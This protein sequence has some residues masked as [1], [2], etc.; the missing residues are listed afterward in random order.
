MDDAVVDKKVSSQ[1]APPALLT[2]PEDQPSNAEPADPDIR[3][4]V[5]IDLTTE[6]R[7]FFDGP[8]PTDVRTWFDGVGLGLE[9]SRCDRY[10]LDGETHIGLKQRAGTI[11]ELKLRQGPPGRIKVGRDLDGQLE[12]WRRWSP[13]DRL[14]YL[15]EHTIWVDIFK[16]ITKRRFLPDGTEA[17]LSRENRAMTGV[18]CDAEVAALEIE[19]EPH[20]TFAF[21]AFG[22]VDSHER[23][24]ETAWASLASGR[25]RPK[26]L[27]L[28]FTRSCGYPSWMANFLS[29][30]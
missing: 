4:D 2:T 5:A 8:L 30:P 9:E 27:R 1:L 17:P 18:G 20:W 25:P 28:D 22:P 26:G 23:S 16:H 21:A 29:L 15:T 7:W 14:T 13:A 19:G 24:L 10:R 12:T 3:V 11:L 6:V